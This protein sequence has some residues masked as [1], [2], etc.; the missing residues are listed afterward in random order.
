MFKVTVTE[1]SLMHTGELM[2]WV[3]QNCHS[4][5]NG[6]ALKDGTGKYYYNLYFDQQSD[7]EWFTLKWFEYIRQEEIS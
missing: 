2:A 4:Y 7:V 6:A 5:S 1:K 3:Y